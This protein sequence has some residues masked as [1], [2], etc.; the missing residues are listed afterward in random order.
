MKNK[1]LF[2]NEYESFYKMAAHSTAFKSYCAEAFGEDFSQDGFSDINQIN[3][4]LEYIPHKDNIHILD[5][6]CGNGKMLKYLQKKTGAFIHG[7]D[8]SENA[9]ADAVKN[10]EKAEFR[11][12]R[13]VK[14]S[15]IQDSLI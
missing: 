12:E 1:L 9:I 14:Q 6:G 2:Y 10:S 7:F 15:I 5:I 4:V 3:R 11:V 8:Y 13:S